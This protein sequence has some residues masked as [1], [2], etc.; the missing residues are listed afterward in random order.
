[1]EFL[2]PERGVEM[3][4][5]RRKFVNLFCAI[6]VTASLVGLFFPTLASV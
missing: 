2:S 6:L 1:M 4:N 3:K 5:A